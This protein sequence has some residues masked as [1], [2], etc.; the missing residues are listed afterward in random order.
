[1]AALP[2]A[3]ARPLSFMMQV[4]AEAAAFDPISGPA[5]TDHAAPNASASSSSPTPPAATRPSSASRPSTPEPARRHQVQNLAK[6]PP[7][8]DDA[9]RSAAPAALAGVKEK[10]RRV[11]ELWHRHGIAVHCG[12]MIGF[13]LDTPDSGREAEWLIE[14]GVDLASFFVVTPLPGTEDHTRRSVRGRSLIGTST[15]TTRSTWCRAPSM[16]KE[17]VLKAYRDAYRLLARNTLR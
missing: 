6:V 5:S 9:G 2:A 17:E 12:Y 4:D 7:E 3:R 13:P 16:T 11:C 15:S 1:M 10:Y 8:E 14:V